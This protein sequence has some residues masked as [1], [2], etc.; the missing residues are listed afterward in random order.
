MPEAPPR[1]HLLR[2]SCD[3]YERVAEW[4][5]RFANH[6]SPTFVRLARSH[7]GRRW[8]CAEE[9]IVGTLETECAQPDTDPVLA[10]LDSI[11]AD[12]LDIPERFLAVLPHS[13]PADA[14]EIVI[15]YDPRAGTFELVDGLNDLIV[16]H[17]DAGPMPTWIGTGAGHIVDVDLQPVIALFSRCPVSTEADEMPPFM[18]VVLAG[19]R[20]EFSRD[21]TPWGLG[22]ERVGMAA[23]VQYRAD[24]SFFAPAAM[25]HL[26]C[27]CHQS[28][29]VE[30]AFFF[31]RPLIVRFAQDDWTLWVLGGHRSV[32]VVRPRIMAALISSGWSVDNDPDGGPSAV[33]AA[34]KGDDHAEIRV[35]PILGDSD[36]IV[37]LECT[38]AER[39]P[40]SDVLGREIAELTA[41]WPGDKVLHRDGRLVVARD[42]SSGACDDLGLLLADLIART[43]A[44]IDVVGVF[45]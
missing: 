15:G 6:G 1:L 19:S 5:I 2:L 35:L 38:V 34:H 28:Y 7:G 11:G 8:I 37:R 42:V 9:N 16:A 33:I 17:V 31:H 23:H 13:L 20:V 43:R 4:A 12:Y 3:E 44:L 24:L 18:R 10:F 45:L 14:Q 26:A 36:A 29:A 41:A 32:T 30:M 39:V 21:L 27:L 40:W 25:A 22:V